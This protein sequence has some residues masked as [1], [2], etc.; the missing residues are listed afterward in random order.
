M[1]PPCI[2]CTLLKPITALPD[3]CSTIE[4]SID[5]L[6]RYSPA[7]NSICD[8]VLRAL[9]RT[10]THPGFRSESSTVDGYVC[11]AA[12]ILYIEHICRSSILASD[13]A[14]AQEALRCL[15]GDLA[16]ASC[17]RAHSIL[18]SSGGVCV[19]CLGGCHFRF[20]RTGCVS[21]PCSDTPSAE[22]LTA[23]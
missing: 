9:E 20:K 10:I 11:V 1:H 5:I 2:D 6:V 13:I 4:Q 16:V 14:K 12:T 7:C 3:T 21:L 19:S 15:Q 22:F 17:A 23:K 8:L 18:C